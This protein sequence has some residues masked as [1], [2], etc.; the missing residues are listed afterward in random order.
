MQNVADVRVELRRTHD[1]DVR[2]LSA[3]VIRLRDRVNVLE[4]QQTELLC[5]HDEQKMELN[6]D[7]IER[8]NAQLSL[9]RRTTD[10]F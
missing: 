1:E 9:E 6:L 8:E 3:E 4:N 10:R 5:L 7:R 2:Q